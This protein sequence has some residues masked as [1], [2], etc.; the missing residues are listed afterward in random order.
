MV[1]VW[2]IL[3]A[4]SLSS[5]LYGKVPRLIVKKTNRL[6]QA[7]VFFKGIFCAARC[8]EIV[9]R[10]SVKVYLHNMYNGNVQQNPLCAAS[11]HLVTYSKIKRIN[12][13]YVTHYTIKLTLGIRTIVYDHSITI[14][15]IYLQLSMNY[16]GGLLSLPLGIR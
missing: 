3:L 5:I 15:Y 7:V 12:R 8:W 2:L 14:E 9:Y 11:C 1:G 10:Q 6:T 13:G 4:A 16:M